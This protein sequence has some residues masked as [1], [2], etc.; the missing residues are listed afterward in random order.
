MI[1]A[2]SVVVTFDVCTRRNEVHLFAS[3]D[4]DGQAFVSVESR[5]ASLK[6]TPDFTQHNKEISFHLHK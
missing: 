3:R 2:D 1:Y 6:F 4:E 5:V